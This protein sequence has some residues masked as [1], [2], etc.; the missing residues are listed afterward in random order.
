MTD[1]LQ[2]N[3]ELLK[4]MRARELREA[5][6]FEQEQAERQEKELGR[7]QRIATQVEQDK[8]VFIAAA[9][10]QAKCDHR[11]GTSGK[12]KWKHIDYMLSKHTFQNGV[13]QFKCLKCRFRAFPGDTREA[14]SYNFEN[15]MKG[16]N[17]VK[18]PNPTGLSY[19]D[20]FRMFQDDTTNS[21]TRSEM[22]VAGPVPVTS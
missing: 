22:V 3:D 10:W 7:K 2:P 1:Q 14:C 18:Y 13:V 12:K 21:E 20:W 5:Q 11:K 15:F 9:E 8:Q 17:K 16:K 4:I 19:A 6:R